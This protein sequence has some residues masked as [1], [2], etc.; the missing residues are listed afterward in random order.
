[1]VE[2]PATKCLYKARL[3]VYVFTIGARAVCLGVVADESG[4]K[5]VLHAINNVGACSSVN[6]NDGGNRG[7]SSTNQA[8]ASGVRQK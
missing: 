6:V 3:M 2:I 1:M 8:G 7:G 5:Q 4:N